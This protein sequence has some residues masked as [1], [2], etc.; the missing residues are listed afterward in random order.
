MDARLG[1]V[2]TAKL[3]RGRVFIAAARLIGRCED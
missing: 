1:L 2:V 3:D